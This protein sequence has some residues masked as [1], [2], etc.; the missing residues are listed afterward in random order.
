MKA[1]RRAFIYSRQEGR[2]KGEATER[3]EGMSSKPSLGQCRGVLIFQVE[4]HEQWP[5]VEASEKHYLF[6]YQGQAWDLYQE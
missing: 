1:F 5:E 2:K 4:S 3:V 6:M